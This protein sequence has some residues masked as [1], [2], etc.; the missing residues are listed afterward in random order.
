MIRV[1]HADQE[2][3]YDALQRLGDV[4][5]TGPVLVQLRQI[6]SLIEQVLVA[7]DPRDMDQKRAPRRAATR[8]EAA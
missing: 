6:A 2:R 7:M 3:L 8:P 1:T 4:R 5:A